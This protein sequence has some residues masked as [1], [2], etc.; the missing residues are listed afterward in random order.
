MVIY[1]YHIKKKKE[2]IKD[3]VDKNLPHPTLICYQAVPEQR[4]WCEISHPN[5]FTLIHLQVSYFQ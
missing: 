3:A 2:H 4:Y 1:D 5:L